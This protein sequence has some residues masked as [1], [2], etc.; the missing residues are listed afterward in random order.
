MILCNLLTFNM[1]WLTAKKFLEY[2]Q[3]L[4]NEVHVT[5]QQPEEY[6]SFFQQ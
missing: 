2:A 6:V 3:C 1:D 4:Q 5:L